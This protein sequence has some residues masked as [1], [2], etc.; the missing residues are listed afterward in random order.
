[1]WITAI[2]QHIISHKCNI[3]MIDIG[4]INHHD[5]A[6]FLLWISSSLVIVFNNQQN[7]CSTGLIFVYFAQ[8]SCV[9]VQL[10]CEKLKIFMETAIR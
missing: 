9:C 6:Y 4:S 5:V 10:W 1:M 3:N 7:I 8:S 2:N